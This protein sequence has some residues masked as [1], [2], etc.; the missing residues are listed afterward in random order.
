MAACVRGL[1]VRGDL[2]GTTMKRDDTNQSTIDGL[3][4][5]I[6]LLRANPT[7]NPSS[8]NGISVFVWEDDDD[9][10]RVV[11]LKKS[12]ETLRAMAPFGE[13]AI[14]RDAG[15]IFVRIKLSASNE[16]VLNIPFAVLLMRPKQLAAELEAAKRMVAA[17]QT[18]VTAVNE[19]TPF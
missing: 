1:D 17:L 2:K 14:S 7:I 8:S 4:K 11:A 10:D 13:F 9:P 12:I 5:A 19:E 6:D 16:F 15:D 18:L 3:Q